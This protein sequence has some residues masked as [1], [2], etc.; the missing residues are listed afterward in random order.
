MHLDDWAMIV[1]NEHEGANLLMLYLINFLV[2]INFNF[3]SFWTDIEIILNFESFD[4]NN[5]YVIEVGI[6]SLASQPNKSNSKSFFVGNA[7]WYN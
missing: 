3:L 1:T 6:H 7:S 2:K 5:Y 4:L